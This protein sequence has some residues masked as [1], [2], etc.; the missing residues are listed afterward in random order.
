MYNYEALWAA[1]DNQSFYMWGGAVSRSLGNADGRN[2]PN[3]LFQF[4]DGN[5]SQVALNSSSIFATLNRPAAGMSAYGNGTGYYLGGY[6]SEV[7]PASNG[8]FSPNTGLMIYNMADNTWKNVT[9]NY[10][11]DG[12]AFFGGMEYA[13]IFGSQGLLVAFGGEES[14]LNGWQDN[15]QLFQPFQTVAVYDPSGP[16]Q[17]YF[18]ETTGDVP[19][20]SDMFCTVGIQSDIGT[21]EM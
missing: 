1:A 9:S 19:P 11:S 3:N 16:G 18:Q 20:Q 7:D 4:K 10:D 13:P 21:Y 12:T 2:K 5:W 6:N 8:P 17:W 15:G 14:N